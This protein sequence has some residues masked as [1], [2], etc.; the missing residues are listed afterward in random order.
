MA[1]FRPL[2]LLLSLLI[3]LTG[4][5][6]VAEHASPSPT[7]AES[8]Q[9]APAEV[10]APEWGEQVYMTAFA[11]EGRDEPVFSPEYRLPKIDNAAGI[12]AYEA[13]NDYYAAALDK[14]A[15]S[16]SDL[17]AWAVDD[18]KTARATGDPF[19]PYVDTEDHQI[20]LQT[21]QVVSILRSHYNNTGGP[22]PQLYPIGDTFDLATGAR[23]TFA[24]LFTCGPTEAAARVLDLL[25]EQNAQGAYRGA[26]L[27]EEALRQAFEPEQFYLTE[28]ALTLFFPEGDLPSALGS[29]TFAIPYSDLED[30]WSLWQ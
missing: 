21:G 19:Y 2:P 26:V 25:L 27:D 15:V 29:P 10:P 30:I 6:T 3:C 24:D 5:S 8:A 9:P 13:I 14:L 17:A 7:P 12:G 23:L 18:Y 22:S 16:A 4:C 1:R 11:A 20:A 28:E